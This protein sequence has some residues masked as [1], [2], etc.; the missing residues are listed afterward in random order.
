MYYF[1][2]TWTDVVWFVISFP[3]L[4]I[5]FFTGSCAFV[6]PNKCGTGTELRS[7][8]PSLYTIASFINACGRTCVI[9]CEKVSRVVDVK[10]AE[11]M[12]NTI[13]CICFTP[14]LYTVQK[15]PI[16]IELFASMNLFDIISSFIN[17]VVIVNHL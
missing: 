12:Y 8:L 14:T 9:Y 6:Y 10:N 5:T 3:L 11:L 13:G 15:K 2:P 4:R 1:S 7:D 16:K 17:S